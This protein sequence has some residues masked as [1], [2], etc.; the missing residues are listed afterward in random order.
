MAMISVI[1]FPLNP[2]P[3]TTAALLFGLAM[4][5]ELLPVQQGRLGL[6]I[7]LT[8]PFIA[9]ACASMGPTAA[10]IGDAGVTLL[11]ALA[12]AL[13]DQNRILW[14]W[15]TV[16]VATAVISVG[17]AGFMREYL[18]SMG[19]NAIEDFAFVAVYVTVNFLIVTRIASRKLSRPF[20]QSVLRNLRSGLV[21]L[22]LYGLIGVAV[23]LVV[24]RGIIPVLP[25]LL[26]PVL[27]LRSALQLNA[28]EEDR[29]YGTMVALTLMLQRAH[30]YTHRHLERVGQLA[31]AVALQLG[32]SPRRAY[33]VREAAV[34]HDIGKIAIDEEILDKPGRLSD[35][36]MDH[37]RMH[38]EFGAEIL[39]HADEF[40]EI[41]PW[42]RW[43]HERPDGTG[44]PE[45][46]QDVEIPIESKIIAVTDAF[47]AM[48]G[49]ALPG[50]VRSY[51]EPMGS[52]D[53]LQ[54]LKRC[55]GTQFDS[56]VVSVFQ[57]VI[58]TAGD[59]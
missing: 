46:L 43:H 14:R 58:L 49:G 36:E 59:A 54:E 17:L 8:L 47:D 9:G 32:L 20:L 6:R 30:P 56:E 42:I 11:A 40:R 7:T 21:C 10:M 5:A 48:V 26:L 50:E 34:L 28:R 18:A 29:Y 57:E 12:V 16:N 51:R 55:A 44:Y 41:V 25:L 15:V 31:E 4:L 2:T 27:A 19:D 24:E 33:K 53:A 13:R 45:R 22:A 23:C 39:A 52:G 1:A 35:D 3:W 37:V 38:P